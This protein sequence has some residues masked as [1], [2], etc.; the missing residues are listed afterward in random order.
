MTQITYAH[1]VVNVIKYRETNLYVSI[2]DLEIRNLV[3]NN[4]NKDS[5]SCF[6]F[7]KLKLNLTLNL[8]IDLNCSNK[9]RSKIG[10]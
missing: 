2:S 10:Q 6:H 3:S 8:R 5:N 9:S 1:L 4:G 7:P